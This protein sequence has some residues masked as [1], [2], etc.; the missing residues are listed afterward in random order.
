M[1]SNLSI[2]LLGGECVL[3]LGLLA[4]LLVRDA[5]GIDGLDVLA[6]QVL[7]LAVLE[8]LVLVAERFDSDLV[9]V[10]DRG[11]LARL[12]LLPLALLV[13]E[14][15]LHLSLVV[16]HA[17][18]LLLEHLRLQALL[19]GRLLAQPCQLLVKLLHILYV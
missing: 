7:E 15:T 3:G 16:V 13:R 6:I 12:A 18:V 10:L 4:L 17:H 14:Q 11:Q 1:V 8:L 2:E 9:V 19:V 5:H